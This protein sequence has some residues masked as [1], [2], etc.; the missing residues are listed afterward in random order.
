MC[1]SAS[2]SGSRVD[3][4][5]C[6]VAV[7]CSDDSF[8]NRAQAMRIATVRKEARLAPRGRLRVSFPLGGK[9]GPP[10]VN[11][12]SRSRDHLGAFVK[13]MGH[14]AARCR[15]ETAFSAG[16]VMVALLALTLSSSIAPA[17]ARSRSRGVVVSPLPGQRFRTGTVWIR[18]RAGNFQGDL[19][20]WLNGHSIGPYFGFSYQGIRSL[21][22]SSSFGLRYGL[23]DL[24]VIAAPEVGR[25][26]S[27]RERFWVSRSAPMAAAGPDVSVAVG[28]RSG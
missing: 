17:A 15:R 1:R 2:H 28:S 4:H 8:V 26:R 11:G 9:A 10:W 19:Q 5:E 3:A 20:V 23:N 14:I 24:H 16:A 25:S 22:V 6:R 7:W 12:L 27:V 18:V 21:Q 13:T